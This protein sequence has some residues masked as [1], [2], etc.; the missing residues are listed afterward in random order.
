MSRN[1]IECLAQDITKKFTTV[2]TFTKASKRPF[3][4]EFA[5]LP[6]T[7]KTTT[8]ASLEKLLRRSGYKVSFIKE[9]AEN[10]P[11]KDKSSVYF[12]IWNLNQTISNMLEAQENNYQIVILDRGIFDSLIWFKWHQNTG[13]IAK[14]ENIILKNYASFWG[15]NNLPDVVFSL[16]A[17]LDLLIKR[18]EQ[19]QIFKKS[20]EIMNEQTL[21]QLH[22]ASLSILQD[23]P[24]SFPNV[25][26]I[27]TG[28]S[29]IQ[30]TARNIAYTVLSNVEEFLDPEILVIPKQLLKDLGIDQTGFFGDDKL[31]RLF[32][33]KM[34][35]YKMVMRRSIAEKSSKYVQPI[36][37]TYLYK[38]DKML[39]LQRI[40]SNP[41]NRL[42][43]K[44]LI[45][46][47]GHIWFKNSPDCLIDTLKKEIREELSL[48]QLIKPQ[49]IGLAYDSSNIKSS[50]HIGIV[51]RSKIK[52]SAITEALSDRILH[53]G[54]YKS[55]HTSI[56]KTSDLTKFLNNM[57]SW[58]KSIL[59]NKFHLA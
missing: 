31:N 2:T 1:E 15:K 25:F 36:P 32:L 26:T 58:S 52:N 3:F 33:D 37:V 38:D 22:K 50:R 21:S 28:S 23:Y 49:F 53:E 47:G 27:N 11:I 44:Y 30:D 55:H 41:T 51:Y 6:K 54:I 18:E 12:N 16:K 8:A 4:V 48:K 45:W 19:T 43:N 39:L 40:E 29:S 7:G 13:R 10:C 5:G 59:S 14:D 46:I 57:E 17:Q 20:G 9:Q 24:D 34:E 35:K 56:V 42:H